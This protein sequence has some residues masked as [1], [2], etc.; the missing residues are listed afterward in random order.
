MPHNPSSRLKRNA[1]TLNKRRIRYPNFKRFVENQKALARLLLEYQRRSAYL[2]AFE[3]DCHLDPIGDL[4]EWNATVH[5]VV[6]AVEGHRLFDLTC[7][8]PLA[9][10][11]ERQLLG[12]GH[13]AYREVAGVIKC[14][15]ARLYNLRRV[16]RD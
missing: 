11:R 14:V 4:N 7:A 3:V 13:S 15:G 1:C 8:C 5:A 12:F 2:L 9:S 6:I 10:K 16:E